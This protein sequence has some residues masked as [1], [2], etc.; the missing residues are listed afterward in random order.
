MEK[1]YSCSFSYAIDC[2]SGKWK[3]MILWHLSNETKRY[4][5]LKK[6]IPNITQKMLTQ[7]LRELERN[8]I[9]NRKVYSVVPPK[10]EYSLTKYGNELIV[11]LD[12]LNR[13]GIKTCNELNIL[14][15]S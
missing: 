6:L 3:G 15:D 10:V 8:H 14:K 4:G 13:W 2:I 12:Q 5:E 9:V 11:I 7:S 1:I